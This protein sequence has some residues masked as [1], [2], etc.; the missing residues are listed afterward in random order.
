MSNRT[1]GRPKS[2]PFLK[3][4]QSRVKMGDWH[5]CW[6]WCGSRRGMYTTYAMVTVDGRQREAHVWSYEMFHGP[7]P[8]ALIVR[9]TCDNP[10]C[11]NPTHLVVGTHLDNLRDML[12]RSRHP[13]VRLSWRQVEEIRLAYTGAYGEQSRLARQYGVRS[14]NINQIVNGKSRRFA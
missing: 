9:H 10:P 11:C 7:V 6:P 5:E 13:A 4:F 1:V 14:Q 12:E 8:P 2:E 3:Q